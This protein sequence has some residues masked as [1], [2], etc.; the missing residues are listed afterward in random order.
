MNEMNSSML[1]VARLEVKV[2][3]LEKQLVDMSIKL[4]TVLQKLAEAKGGWR[5]LMW[6]GGSAAS[7]GAFAAWAF[8]HLALK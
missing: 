2:Q 8:S 4:D 7:L 6:L 1:Q 5:T 3:H